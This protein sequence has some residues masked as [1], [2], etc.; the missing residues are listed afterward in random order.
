MNP[1]QV[2]EIFV[3]QGVV[4]KSQVEDILQEVNSTGKG[5][6]AI[7]ARRTNLKSS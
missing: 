5:L 7:S 2:L 4:E 3:D 1:K 6:L